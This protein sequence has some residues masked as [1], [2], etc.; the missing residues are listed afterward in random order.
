MVADDDRAAFAEQGIPSQPWGELRV[1]KP[2]AEEFAGRGEDVFMNRLIM[3]ALFVWT[4][5]STTMTAC[6]NC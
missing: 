4:A 5:A 3:V 1:L 6:S 2:T